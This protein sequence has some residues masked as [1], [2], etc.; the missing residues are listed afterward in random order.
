VSA[1]RELPASLTIIAAYL[2][3][4]GTHLMQ[5]FLPNTEAP[6][7]AGPSSGPAGFIYVTSNGSSIRH[8][9]QITLRRRLYA[10]LMASVDYTL[11]KATDDAATFGSGARTPAA[12]SIAQDWRD[13]VAERGPSSFDQRHH[14]DVQ[15][16]YTTGV[17][18]KGGTLIDG[19]WGSLW[20]DWTIATE[21]SA[22]SALPFTPI[23]FLPV[24]GTGVIGIRAST[25]GIS[26]AP[27]APRT[28]AN[29]AAFTVPAP[30]TW[31]N[32]GRNSLR[33]PA[34]FSMDLSVARVFRLRT[35][36]NLEWRIAATNVLNRV[37]FA[38]VDAIVGS[39][40]FG[41]P[42][43]ANPMRTVQMTTRLRF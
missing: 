12:L 6:G 9:A 39:P 32:A 29:P 33:G 35:R 3:T 2:G 14:V 37:T 8:A 10:G 30:G 43:V 24:A 20:K 31:G 4:R 5:A 28:Y 22:G 1:Q 15:I 11:A 25:T 36:L 26:P 40:Q 16:Q 19:L 7:S 41:Q 17:G 21:I 23:A 42:T 13:L 38:A 27:V 18:L 34:A